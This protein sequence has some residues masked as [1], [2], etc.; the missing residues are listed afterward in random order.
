MLILVVFYRSER[1]TRKWLGDQL[2]VDAE[3]LEMIS[4][5][6]IT[7]TRIGRYF[8]TI[9]DHFPPEMVFDMVCYL[10]VHVE[11]SITAKGV[12]MMREAGFDADTPSGT[13]EKFEELRHLEKTIGRTGRLALLPFL[14]GSAQDRWQLHMLEQIVG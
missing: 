3:L 8:Q 7:E 12:L 13:K 11:L 4:T 1:S 5:G 2:D 14:H 10:R 9:R 6:R